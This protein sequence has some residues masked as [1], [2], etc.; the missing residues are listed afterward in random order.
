M[1]WTVERDGQD[2]KQDLGLGHHE[3]HGWRGFHHPAT[4]SIVASGIPMALRLNPGSDVG[5]KNF[6]PRKS[7]SLSLPRITSLGAA[8][9]VQRH[10]TYSI[11]TL[12]FEPGA[13]LAIAPGH[14]PQCNSVNLRLRL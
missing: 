8:L 10:V 12:R 11:T 3:R 13:A 9:R 6:V 4:S 7:P 14:C 5:G 1:R 2:L